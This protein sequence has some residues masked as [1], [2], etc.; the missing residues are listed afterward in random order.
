MALQGSALKKK[1]KAKTEC[2]NS[3]P[4][5]PASA[6]TSTDGLLPSASVTVAVLPA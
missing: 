2:S 6:I 3:V 1:G 4:A 5:T